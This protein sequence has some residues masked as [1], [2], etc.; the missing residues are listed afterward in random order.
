VF[1]RVDPGLPA[2]LLPPH[3]PVDQAWTTFATLHERW[4]A[5]GLAHVKA[6]V[7]G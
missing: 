6:V 1:P 4:A 5:P 2:T 7:A 3:W